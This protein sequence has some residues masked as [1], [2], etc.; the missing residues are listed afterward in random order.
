M[1]GKFEAGRNG[2]RRP[3]K[4][5]RRRLNPNFVLTCLALLAVALFVVIRLAEGGNPPERPTDPTSVTEET[6]KNG[7]FGSK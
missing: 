6:Q 5:R 1:S 4:R 2:R 3:Q 7:W